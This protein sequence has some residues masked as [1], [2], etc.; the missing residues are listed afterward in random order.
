VA[1]RA[2]IARKHGIAHLAPKLVGETAEELDADAQA[3]A[4]LIRML[5][6]RKL[7]EEPVEQ[8]QSVEGM[9][10]ANKPF[11]QYTDEEPEAQHEHT[12][13][14]LERRERAQAEAEREREAQA[15]R[16]PQQQVGDLASALLQP[17]VKQDAYRRLVESLH[18]SQ[19]EGSGGGFGV[20]PS[21]RDERP[22]GFELRNYEPG[23]EPFPGS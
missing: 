3:K 14:V 15:N 5:S 9:A 18:G 23:N 4:A 6:P 8:P 12:R 1:D 20:T 11:D 10:P 21:P 16:S 13:R 17:R 2:E 22:P 7:D 19:A